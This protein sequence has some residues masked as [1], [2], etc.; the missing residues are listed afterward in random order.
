MIILDANDH[1]GMS[2][3][4]TAH[5]WLSEDE[6]IKN[7]SKPGEGNMN[8]VTR[9]DTGKRTFIIKQSRA[10]VEKYP[11]VAAPVERI[12][13]EGA[14]Y[15]KIAGNESLKSFMPIL[16][17]LDLENYIMMLEDLGESK[18]FTRIYNKDEMVS[19]DELKSLIRYL[20]SLHESY[21]SQ[22]SDV[23]F[24]NKNMKLLNHEHIFKYPFLMN[25]GFDLDII[26]PGL[27]NI[28]MC[29]KTDDN[30]KSIVSE[31]GEWYLSE[32]NYLLHGDFYPGSWLF[33]NSGIKI[34]DPEFCFYGSREFDIS[35]LA[36]H[37]I[38]ARQNQSTI[39]LISQI[40]PNYHT[41]NVTLVRRMTGVEIMR[42]LIGLAQLP[43][44]MNLAEKK[45]MLE[46]ACQM[47]K[48]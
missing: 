1:N 2:A 6:S 11:Q 7:I 33:T 22:T 24:S 13:T 44:E 32:G 20:Y 21:F 42:R 46:Q 36:A 3:Y 18:D 16:R 40:Y 48:K 29:Y 37:L 47:I 15:H 27:Q 41:L 26:T 14:F 30:L 9:I 4:L 34:I 25:N 38:L 28:A 10:Y 39:N 23:V 17:G 5:C 19:E 31:L 43:L 35:I 12:V 45:Q 8:F